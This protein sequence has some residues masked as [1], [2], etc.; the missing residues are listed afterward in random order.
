MIVLCYLHVR[1][2]TVG[3]WSNSISRHL[4]FISVGN[5]HGCQTVEKKN[6]NGCTIHC[7]V[8]TLASQR[9]QH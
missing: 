5:L 8:R 2:L 3:V 1:I 4:G 6:N 7:T 9:K